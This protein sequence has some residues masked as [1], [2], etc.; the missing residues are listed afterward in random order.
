MI[1]ACVDSSRVEHP[2]QP[3]GGGAIPTST[4]QLRKKDW[5]VANVDQDTADRLVREYHYAKGASNT[6][7]YLHGLYPVGWHWYSH[8]VGVAWWIPPT[9]S[10]AEAW[11]GKLWEGV[12]SLSRLVIEPEVP[13]NAC[14]FLLSKS[15]RKID[16]QR[17]HTLVTYADSWRGHTGAIYRAA[18]W[19][20]AGE[21]KPE[22]IYT[23]N[24]RMTARKAGARTRTHAAMLA[25]GAKFEGRHSKSRFVLRSPTITAAHKTGD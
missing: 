13:A 8:C 15:V 19:E 24:G 4:L 5:E 6:A 25:L 2:A 20:Y 23:I 9:R 10:A 21:T 22:A 17:W 18:G 14:S 7:V 3:G 11:A 16:R 12:L 1:L